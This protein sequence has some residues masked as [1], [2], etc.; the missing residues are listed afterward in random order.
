ML[1]LLACIA[2]L[3]RDVTHHYFTGLQTTHGVMLE[4]AHADGRRSGKCSIV[5]DHEYVS[6]PCTK[7]CTIVVPPA[8]MPLDPHR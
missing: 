6:R 2:E 3:A 7:R 1:S 8:P 4:A 5:H